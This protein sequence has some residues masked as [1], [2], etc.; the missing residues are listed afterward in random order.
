MRQKVLRAN[1]KDVA[2]VA[3]VSMQ[4]VSRVLNERP[5]VS[6]ETRK[7]VK[8]VIKQV[9]YR[10]SALARSLSSHRSYTLGVITAGLKY[11]GPS[12]AVSG[13]ASAAKEA[14]YSLILDELPRFDADNLEPIFH[15]LISRHV[16]GIIW[17]VPEV[18]ENR[19]WLNNPPLNGQIPL[20]YLTM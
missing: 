1:I 10:P 12:N 18:G 15:A 2:S 4:T 9:G 20:I 8:D 17:A 14:G 6:P 16:D 5:D 13:I 7:R 3:G 11:I 19:N